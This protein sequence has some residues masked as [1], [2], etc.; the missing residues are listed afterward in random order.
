MMNITLGIF[1][2]H[3]WLCTVQGIAL[4]FAGINFFYTIRTWPL[5]SLLRL[6]YLLKVCDNKIKEQKRVIDEINALSSD[7]GDT[8]AE[9]YTQRGDTVQA[10]NDGRG[11]KTITKTGDGLYTET[12]K[13]V[14]KAGMDRPSLHERLAA[15]VTASGLSDGKADGITVQVDG[16]AA[17][18]CK[19]SY[20]ARTRSIDVAC[21]TTPVEGSVITVSYALELS[22]DAKDAYTGKGEGAYDAAGD[23]DTGATSAGR[24]GF[25]T[26]NGSTASLLPW[27]TGGGLI[28]ALGTAIAWRRYQASL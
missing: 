9:P 18:G 20:T 6:P 5:F 3:T 26:G 8:L 11:S 16:K 15:N 27:I 19:A 17:T 4:I 7:T 25:A 12:L 23:K 13:A 2:A 21:D 14:V 10:D 22:D 28:I 24:K 1:Y